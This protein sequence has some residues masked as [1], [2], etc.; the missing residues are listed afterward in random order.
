[1][2]RHL[3]GGG[4]APGPLGKGEALD[5]QR[6]HLRPGAEDVSGPAPAGAAPP[7]ARDPGTSAPPALPARKRKV[8][9]TLHFYIGREILKSLLLVMVIF[10]TVLGT[11]FAFGAVR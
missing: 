11:I 8:S 4:E 9:R 7:S 10:E 6:A 3:P 5:R 1:R 2:S